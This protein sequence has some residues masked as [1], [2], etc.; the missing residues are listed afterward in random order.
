MFLPIPNYAS[1]NTEKQ[2]G[3]LPVIGRKLFN[4][5]RRKLEQ[6]LPKTHFKTRRARHTM[7]LVGA[8]KRGITKADADQGGQRKRVLILVDV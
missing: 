8:H 2:Q 4:C 6:A 7:I 5:E 3:L 1:P